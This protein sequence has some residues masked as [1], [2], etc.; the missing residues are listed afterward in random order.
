MTVSGK[1]SFSYGRDK[2]IALENVSFYQVCERNNGW[3]E[4]RPEPEKAD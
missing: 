2:A 3:S 4:D 1:A